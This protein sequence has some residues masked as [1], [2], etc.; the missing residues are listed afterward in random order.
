VLALDRRVAPR[1]AIEFERLAVDRR[2]GGH[3]ACAQLDRQADAIARAG[4]RDR[5]RSVERD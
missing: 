5:P 2:R 1:A 4:Y 3:S